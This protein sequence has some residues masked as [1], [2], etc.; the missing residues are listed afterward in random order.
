MKIL[1]FWFNFHLSLFIRIQLTINEHC[2]GNGL[3]PVR[4]QAIT[5]TDADPVHWRIYQSGTKPNL[6]AK[7]F[8]T[9]FG[10]FFVI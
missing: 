9:N 4:R 7:I 6:V 5:W 10:V 2:L 1:E 8:A 3:S